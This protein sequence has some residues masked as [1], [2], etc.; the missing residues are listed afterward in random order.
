MASNTIRERVYDFL[1]EF[2]PFSLMARESLLDLSAHVSISYYE[3]GEFIFRQGDDPHSHFFIVRQG[4]AELRQEAGDDDRLVDVCDEGD[5]FGVRAMISQL[6]YISNAVA[7][8]ETL[9][10]GIPSDHFKP[11][12]TDNPKVALFFAAGFAAG[13]PVVRANLFDTRRG[14]RSLS[15]KASPDFSI[16]RLGEIFS[17]ETSRKLVVCHARDTVKKVAEQMSG[18]EVGSIIVVDELNYP[19]GMITDTDLRKKVATGKVSIHQPVSA[20]M[21][22]PV[23][24]IGPSRSVA[25]ILIHM[26]RERVH[27]LCITVDGTAD[28]EAI[29]IISE[30]DLL[31]RQ[32]SNPV[33]IL[34]E[35]EKS[36]N[37]SA[38]PVLRDRTDELLRYYLQQEVSIANVSGVVSE[39]NDALVRKALQHAEKMLEDDGM[40][41]PGLSYCWL[42]F[43]SDGREERLLRTRQ[44]NGLLYEDPPKGK[45]KTAAKYFFRLATEVNQVL[46]ACGFG[47]CKE[48]IMAGSKKWC[49]P[50]S[51]WEKCYGDWI[52]KAE[53]KVVASIKAMLDYMPVHG[54]TT[55]AVKLTDSIFS[56]IGEKEPFLNTLAANSLQ[57]TPPLGF[58]RNLLVER[59]G[60]HH[61]SFDIKMRAM[62]PLIDAAR[63]LI[64]QQKVTGVN[65]TLR[66]FEKLAELEPQH[67]NLYREAAVA[68]EIMMLFRTQTGLKGS[69]PDNSPIQE[70]NKIE[71]KTLRNAFQPIAELQSLIK[72]RFQADRSVT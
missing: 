47:E 43:G 38:L 52:N 30:H 65:N 45:E 23:V 7:K 66:R 6:P 9:L 64:L 70:L 20:I 36:T 17:T 67:A 40:V 32:G 63:L 31:L 61:D 14:S 71:R 34:R 22:R 10:Y 19:T 3:K 8:E 13:Q 1:R 56:L 2:P 28:S 68:F 54:D 59:S 57:D 18:E 48:G 37:L 51:G 26:M 58:F 72:G 27:H 53:P 12:L 11:L 39:I 24:T 60:E 4:S 29:G 25:D 69:E 35:I 33:V 41:P 44:Q 46:K 15:S 16:F 42:A 21:S 62:T 55:L 5:V 49:Q 50:L